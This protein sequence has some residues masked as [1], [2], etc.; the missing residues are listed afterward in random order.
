MSDDL[1]SARTSPRSE[2]TAM[3]T[4]WPGTQYG[5][6]SR[7]G[8]P[9]RFSSLR[10]LWQLSRLSRPCEDKLGMGRSFMIAPLNWYSGPVRAVLA[11]VYSGLTLTTDLGS[12]SC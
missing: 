7:L 6:F 4:G 2:R 11:N 8:S 12:N 9:G 10:A 5:S 3:S 1:T